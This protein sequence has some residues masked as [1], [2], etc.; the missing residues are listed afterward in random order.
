MI[1]QYI[2]HP[3]CIILAVSPANADLANSDALQMARQA[4]PDGMYALQ[5]PPLVQ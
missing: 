3:S 1:M 2:K 5:S 4:D